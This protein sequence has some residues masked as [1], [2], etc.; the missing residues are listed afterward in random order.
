MNTVAEQLER[1]FN[2]MLQTPEYQLH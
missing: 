2:V 1:L